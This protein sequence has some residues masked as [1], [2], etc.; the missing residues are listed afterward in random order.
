MAPPD[1]HFKH[2]FVKDQSVEI[3]KN[4]WSSRALSTTRSSTVA[5][6]YT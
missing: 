5:Y 3:L 1:L 2:I 6:I 4:I